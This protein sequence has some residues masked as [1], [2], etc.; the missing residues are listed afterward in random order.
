MCLGC[1]VQHFA[2]RGVPVPETTA[3]MS[4]LAGYI[5]AFL[6]DYPLGG[7]LHIVLA[8]WNLDDDAI[9]WCQIENDLRK[10]EQV[11]ARRLL[12]LSEDKRYVVLG[13]ASFG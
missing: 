8:D 13:T 12:A 7:G 11:I 9:R 5:C 2:D 4:E 3:E 1:Y 6:A 10:A